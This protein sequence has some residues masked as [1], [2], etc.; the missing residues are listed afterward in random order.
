MAELNEFLRQA[1]RLRDRMEE[2]AERASTA[3]HMQDRPPRYSQALRDLETRQQSTPP[4]MYHTSHIPVPVA[5]VGTQRRSDTGALFSASTTRRPENGNET[6]PVVRTE[7][8]HTQRDTNRPAPATI[9]QEETTSHVACRTSIPLPQEAL[10]LTDSEVSEITTQLYQIFFDT[11]P[12]MPIQQ[13]R[14]YARSLRNAMLPHIQSSST[15]QR[16]VTELVSGPSSRSEPMGGPN[17]LNAR[18]ATDTFSEHS[19]VNGQVNGTESVPLYALADFSLDSVENPALSDSSRAK[20]IRLPPDFHQLL[21]NR[22]NGTTRSLSQSAHVNGT[23]TPA[24]QFSSS[25][26]SEATLVNSPSG[27]ELPVINH[28]VPLLCEDESDEETPVVEIRTSS[29]EHSDGEAPTRETH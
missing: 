26:S 24:S 2:Y 20:L 12:D 29:G 4:R 25:G 28:I 13:A 3:L 10:I 16:P 14:Y 23:D 15:L 6:I 17:S 11:H 9:T 27:D 7:G 19:S 5:T 8:D 22:I 18:P 21:A 1:T